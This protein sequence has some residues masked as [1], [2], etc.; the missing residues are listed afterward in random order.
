[1]CGTDGESPQKVLQFHFVLPVLGKIRN[2]HA[3]EGSFLVECLVLDLHIDEDLGS[4]RAGA[5]KKSSDGLESG[6]EVEFL[7]GGGRGRAEM[8]VRPNRGDL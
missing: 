1:M 4:R 7:R 5:D 6:P 3:L 8:F 2:H